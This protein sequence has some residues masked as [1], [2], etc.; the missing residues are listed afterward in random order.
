VADNPQAE[1]KIYWEGWSL[2]W[3]ADEG[4]EDGWGAN[5]TGR[6]SWSHNVKRKK[7]SHGEAK[8]R[9]PLETLPVKAINPRSF[10]QQK[11]NPWRSN[12]KR[13]KSSLASGRARRD[14]SGKELAEQGIILIETKGGGGGPME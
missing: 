13:G 4:R 2:Q 11:K 5:Y 12:D 6:G 1:R 3:A 7:K 10:A 8:A 14:A 9:Q